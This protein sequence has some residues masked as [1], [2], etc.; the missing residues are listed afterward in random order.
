MTP[1]DVAVLQYTGGTTGV[2]KGAMLT[3]RNIVAN[4]LQSEM[5]NSPALRRNAEGEQSIIVCALPIYHIFG[6]TV[7]L[8]LS[9]R[10]GGAAILIPNPRDIA[11]TLKAIKPFRFQSFPAV[12]TLYNAIALHPDAKPS[13]GRR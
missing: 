1:A 5:W 3:H 9:V 8:M 11:A 13:T 6:F 4:V 10:S 7:N 2:A 12:N